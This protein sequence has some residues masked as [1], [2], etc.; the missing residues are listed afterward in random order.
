MK[1]KPK[2]CPKCGSG[3]VASIL[4]GLPMFNEK[5]ERGLE[6]G[7]VILGGC[8]VTYDDPL[9]QCN[10]RWGN[11]GARISTNEN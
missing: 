6:S 2:K 1:S 7:E 8:C 5:L 3:K 9:W 11:T 10:H 4:Y